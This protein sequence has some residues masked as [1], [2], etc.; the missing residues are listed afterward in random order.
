MTAEI[1]IGGARPGGLFSL[2]GERS[3]CSSVI[4][5]CNVKEDSARGVRKEINFY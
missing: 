5:N 2:R 4:I 1:N 3:S